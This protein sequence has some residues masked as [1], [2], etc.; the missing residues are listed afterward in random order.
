MFRVRRRQRDPSKT[1]LATR[2]NTAWTASI[3]T[4]WALSQP[5][6][7]NIPSHFDDLDPSRYNKV[8]SRFVSETKRSDGYQYKSN[9]LY[10]LANGLNR[11]VK[12]LHKGQDLDLF[13]SSQFAPFRDV[14]DALLL[15]RKD[16]NT[17]PLSPK[18][19]MTFDKEELLWRNSLGHSNPL[20]SLTT[21]IYV[22]LRTFIM[23]GNETMKHLTFQDFQY[24]H[25]TD[26]D[27]VIIFQRDGVP[28]GSH[29]ES[30]KNSRGFYQNMVKYLARCPEAVRQGE[31]PLFQHPLKNWDVMPGTEWFHIDKPLGC[32]FFAKL[33]KDAFVKAGVDGG[34]TLSAIR[35][36]AEG[37]REG[38][39]P[40]KGATKGNSRRGKC[41]K[42]LACRTSKG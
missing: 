10:Q 28:V 37:L 40:A 4:T 36:F 33:V 24:D 17:V 1:N 30:T 22:A 12:D 18:D 15:T 11:R 35:T 8:L 7:H 29:F 6:E 20:Q 25:I 31:V 32:N 3:Y 9:T 41:I 27:V 19:L 21:C 39:K 2:K 26:E 16:A 5:P 14:L 42:G 13:N 38:T 34:C 23:K